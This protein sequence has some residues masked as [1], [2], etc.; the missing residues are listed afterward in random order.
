MGIFEVVGIVAFV[1]LMIS[2]FNSEE[3]WSVWP[4]LGSAAVL[5]ICVVCGVAMES[6]QPKTIE[7]T[8][9]PQIDTVITIKNNVSDTTYVYTFIKKEDEQ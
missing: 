4:G 7:T 8:H 3:D 5:F 1:V 6:K 9:P 2:V